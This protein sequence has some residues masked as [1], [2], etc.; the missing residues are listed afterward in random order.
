[1]GLGLVGCGKVWSGLGDLI[2]SDRLDKALERLKA[3]QKLIDRIKESID[4][5][6]ELNDWEVDF[7]D[8]VFNQLLEDKRQVLSPKQWDSLEKIEFKRAGGEQAYWEE[9][10]ERG[11]Y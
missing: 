5:S 3:K 2:V 8:S 9:F 10:G 7:L 6:G 1:L 4:D 11:G